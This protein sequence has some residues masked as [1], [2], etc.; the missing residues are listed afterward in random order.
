VSKQSIF[1]NEELAYEYER[2]MEL[3]EAQLTFLER[4]EQ[5][6]ERGF[7]I[8]G[9]LITSPDDKQKAI[10]VTM[11]LLRALQQDDQPKIAVSCAYLSTRLPHVVE[12]HARDQ[13]ER[14]V[15][16]FVEEH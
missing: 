4:M 16:E 14:I 13:D 12:V 10:F 15:V 9:E 6:M 1:V 3:D 5:D 2:S 8:H 11:N 7:R